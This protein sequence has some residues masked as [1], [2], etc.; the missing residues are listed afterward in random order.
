MGPYLNTKENLTPLQG[1]IVRQMLE[2]PKIINELN[3]NKRK[4]THW[5]WWVW[6]TDRQGRSETKIRNTKTCIQDYQIKELLEKTDVEQWTTI[7]KLI[8][9]FI[10]DNQ[11]LSKVIPKI[12]H[13]RMEAFYLL[14]L[15]NRD[16][17]YREFFDEIKKQQELFYKYKI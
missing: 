13:G 8:N 7:L 9:Q 14:F 16:E 17:D 4:V 15:N 12:D 5:A 1:L 10:Y 2:F 11:S 3:E 6:P